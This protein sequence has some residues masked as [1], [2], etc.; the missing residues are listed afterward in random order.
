MSQL[1]LVDG[2]RSLFCYR[3]TEHMYLPIPRFALQEAL[4]H[5]VGTRRLGVLYADYFDASTGVL[6]FQWGQTRTAWTNVSL[7][8][9]VVDHWRR[10]FTIRVGGESRHSFHYRRRRAVAFGWAGFQPTEVDLDY[11]LSLVSRPSD[12][13]Q[14]AS[15]GYAQ[16]WR[17]TGG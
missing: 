4:V 11:F 17:A 12:W 1:V 5:G 16:G 10:R 8:N 9:E 14:Q 2:Y 7:S 3:I 6:L 15:D 13:S